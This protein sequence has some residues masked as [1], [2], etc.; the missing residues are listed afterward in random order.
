MVFPRVTQYN[1]ITLKGL[2]SVFEMRTGVSPKVMIANKE[3]K[4]KSVYKGF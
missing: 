4:I 3:K 2:T 1:T